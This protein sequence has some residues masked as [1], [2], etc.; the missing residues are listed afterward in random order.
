MK[1]FNE[2]RALRS[3]NRP[4][5]SRLRIEFDELGEKYGY[6]EF[7]EFEN[8]EFRNIAFENIILTNRNKKT[9]N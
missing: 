6:D 9:F 8:K 7:L 3:K 2:R 1:V 5:F 4:G